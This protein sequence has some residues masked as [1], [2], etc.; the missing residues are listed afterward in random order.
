MQCISKV[1]PIKGETTLLKVQQIFWV[2]ACMF[3]PRKNFL[4][5][6]AHRYLILSE[7]LKTVANNCWERSCYTF[8]LLE[9]GFISDLSELPERPRSLH[10]ISIDFG[11]VCIKLENIFSNLPSIKT[12]TVPICNCVKAGR[13]QYMDEIINH[14]VPQKW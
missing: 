1:S 13:F 6:I 12:V 7:K 11:V 4:S 5:N 10:Q 8:L 14:K 3:S 2:F 9:K